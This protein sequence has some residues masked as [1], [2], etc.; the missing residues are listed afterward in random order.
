MFVFA[1]ERA[2]FKKPSLCLAWWFGWG[3]DEEKSKFEKLIKECEAF[4]KS[5]VGGGIYKYKAHYFKYFFGEEE[6]DFAF[7]NWIIENEGR[8][9]DLFITKLKEFAENKAVQEAKNEAQKL[10]D[11]NGF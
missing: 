5:N 9:E 11:K 7:A 6:S 3:N 10:L 8:A 1:Q 2:D 4:F